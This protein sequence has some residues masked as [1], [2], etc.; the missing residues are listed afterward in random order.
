MNQTIHHP[1]TSGS[2]SEESHHDCQRLRVKRSGPVSPRFDAG[3]ARAAAAS[4][5][6]QRGTAAGFNQ[7][8]G[9]GPFHSRPP[10]PLPRL[11][12][13]RRGALVA[14]AAG[15]A[16]AAG[17]G[18]TTISTATAAKSAKTAAAAEAAGAAAAAVL[19]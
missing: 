16:T 13:V 14:Q 9:R 12:A 10:P 19:N 8:P 4:G 15:S 1:C 11:R 18:S 5:A 17:V 3:A 7:N 6:R 2:D